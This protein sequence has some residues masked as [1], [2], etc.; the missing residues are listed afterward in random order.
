MRSA[1][2]SRILALVWVVSVMNPAWLP[3]NDSAVDA[4]VV[5]RHA[6]QRG[7][8]ALAGGDEHVHLAAR[9]GCRDTSSARRSSSSVS[10]PMALTTT[11]TS[12]PRRMRAG[13][14]V[15]DG[16]D[17]IGIGDRGATELLDEES[18]GRTRYRPTG[19]TPTEIE[20]RIP[21]V[22]PTVDDRAVACAAWP[23]DRQRVIAPSGWTAKRR[24]GRR[25]PAPI[26]DAS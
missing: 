6:Q 16:A 21:L 24:S 11:T 13:D 4:D 10:L 25:S 26:G 15:G 17:A 19:G 14:V 18:H 1:R 22:T 9:A 8:L 12:L 20:D 3:V 23:T 7:G 5:Q 2:T